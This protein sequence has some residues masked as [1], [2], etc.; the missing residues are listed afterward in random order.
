VSDLAEVDQE[1][2]RALLAAEFRVWDRLKQLDT[3]SAK[4]GEG[5]GKQIDYDM[6]RC[7]PDPGARPAWDSDPPPD[8]RRAELFSWAVV[9]RLGLDQKQHLAGVRNM[10]L[11]GM[12]VTVSGPGFETWPRRCF[13]STNI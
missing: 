3:L 2:E 1:G 12:Y 11:V 8:H 5:G 7:S 9:R 6:Q 10:M 4:T 13:S